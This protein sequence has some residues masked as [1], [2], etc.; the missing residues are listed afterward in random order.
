SFSRRSVVTIAGIF[1]FTVC[2]PPSTSRV[3]VRAS[4]SS[5]TLEAKV[6]CGQPS[7]AASIWPVWLQSSSIA[8]LPMMTRPGCSASAMA[9][10]I[11]ATASGSTGPSA[12][13]RMPRSAPMASA[14]RMVSAACCGPIETAM[15]SVAL[16]AS[17]RR[18][19]SS[20]AISSNGF[21]DILTL[22]SS[23]PEPS[24]LTRIFTSLSM[25]R[26][27]GTRIFIAVGLAWFRYDRPAL[28]SAYAAVREPTGRNGNE[29]T[30][31][32]QR[33]EVAGDDRGLRV[34]AIEQFDARRPQPNEQPGAGDETADM[35]PVGDAVRRPARHFDH[36]PDRP[37]PDH[38]VGADAQR[39][40]AE[41]ARHLG[42]RPE[43]Q[44]GGNDAGDRARGAD[45][46][47]GRG[48]IVEHER[49]VPAEAARQIEAE[50]APVPQH[51]LDVVAEHE[52]EQHIAEHVHEIGVQEHRGD[53]RE[54][55]P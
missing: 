13:T 22:P 44:I 18:S 12:L 42:A 21:I 26:F 40:E 3:T 16:P 31:A 48:R 29:S 23:T 53:E 14:V 50:K 37:G 33:V 27:T 32:S 51:L 9:L 47:G 55:R 5:A 24:A 45:Q 8:C 54:R 28:G 49:Q 7:S 17:L 46:L 39:Y 52:Q 1:S 2:S 15:I 34:L 43:Q 41:Q 30:R 38:P 25:A 20:T 4:P 6:P 36:L 19:A 10:R 11:F 35:R